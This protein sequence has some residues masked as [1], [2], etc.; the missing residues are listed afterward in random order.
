MLSFSFNGEIQK[1]SSSVFCKIKNNLIKLKTKEEIEKNI[2]R[3][4]RGQ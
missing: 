4:Q 1:K 2:N 3:A